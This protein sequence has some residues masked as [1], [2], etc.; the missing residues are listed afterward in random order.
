[1]FVLTRIKTTRAG[2]ASLASLGIGF[3][4]IT[5]AAALVPHLPATPA[6]PGIDVRARARTPLLDDFDRVARPIGVAYDPL[7]LMAAADVT[8]Q[9]SL[10]VRPDSRLE[11]Q[12]IRVI[13][14]G[15]VSLPAGDYRL[16]VDWIGDRRGEK[17]GLQIGR[18]GDAWR[19]WEV[20]PRP[21][22]HWST[23]FTLPFD[24]GFVGLRGTPELEK[25][26]GRIAFVPVSVVDRGRRPRF[27]EI[28]GAS[29]MPGTDYFYFDENALPEARGFWIRGA[30]TTRVLIQ[31]EHA[32][33]PLKLRLNS[34]LIANRLR[35]STAGWTDTV[36]LEPRIP[37]AIDVPVSDR[38]LVTLELA[39][40]REF[41]PRTLDPSSRDHRTLGIWV[42]VIEP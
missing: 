23:E 2:F 31:R 24:A 16:D 28:L 41:V 27:P 20:E 36:P 37:G 29:S 8:T 40:D 33:G 14:N 39:A 22:E 3:I 13:H 38:S 32:A 10:E 26:I 35:I 6:W 11:P 34:G 42:E 17:L 7:R 18:T 12:P 21:G 25:T 15:R 4:A 30:R 1:M 5:T 9:S 19:S